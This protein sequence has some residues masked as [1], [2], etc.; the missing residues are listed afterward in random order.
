MSAIELFFST[1][2]AL[3]YLALKFDAIIFLHL[4]YHKQY[5]IPQLVSQKASK[6]F[7]PLLK[8]NL[9]STSS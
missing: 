3:K 1:L 7:G 2:L 4:S 8:R 9:V 5:Q 6:E